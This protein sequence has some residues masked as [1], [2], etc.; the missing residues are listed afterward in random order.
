[1]NARHLTGL[2]LITVALGDLTVI[3]QP[4]VVVGQSEVEAIGGVGR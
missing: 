4:L 3:A 1:M 2:V